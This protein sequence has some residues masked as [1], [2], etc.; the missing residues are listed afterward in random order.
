MLLRCGDFL[1]FN[2][3]I[4][5]QRT[6][7]LATTTQAVMHVDKY[8]LKAEEELTRFEFISEGPRGTFR[9][10][11]E[12]QG[13]F[14]PDVFNLAFGDKHSVTGSLD[15]LAVTD[16]GDTEKVLAT[17]V[18]AVYTFLTQHPT[19]YVYAQGSTSARTRL[20]RMGINRFYEEM[21]QDFFLYG[22]IGEDFLDFEPDQE[23]EGFLA[24][25]RLS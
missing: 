25:R 18:A 24:Q 17:V 3:R 1:N 4:N 2:K 11:I 19:A 6:T 15:D 14:D 22:R 10:L 8:Q 12:F 20:Y 13:T 5:I 9:K 7:N 16:N 23:Y 21:R